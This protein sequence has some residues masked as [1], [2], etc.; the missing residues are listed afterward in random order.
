[1][2]QDANLFQ[3]LTTDQQFPYDA[4]KFGYLGALE[5]FVPIVLAWHTTPFRRSTIRKKQQMTVGS[6]GPG[7]STDYFPRVLNAFF[8]SEVQGRARLQGLRR[9]HARDRARRDWM[10]SPRGATTA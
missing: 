6:D 4:R 1:M 10:G 2:L 5:K 9:H 3:Q 8:G 7:S